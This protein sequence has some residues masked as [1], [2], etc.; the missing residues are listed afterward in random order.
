MESCTPE[1]KTQTDPS[2]DWADRLGALQ[3]NYTYSIENPYSAYFHSKLP[4]C[5]RPII[6]IITGQ[7]LLM[8][9]N[10][11]KDKTFSTLYNLNHE[12][13]KN[14]EDFL[15][16]FLNNLYEQFDN[17]SSKKTYDDDLEKDQPKYKDQAALKR[18]KKS[19]HQFA[20]EFG[21]EKKLYNLNKLARKLDGVTDKENIKNLLQQG[22]N[23]NQQYVYIPDYTE[24]IISTKEKLKRRKLK[25]IFYWISFFVSIIVGFG[26]ALVA[27]FFA[28]SSWPLLIALLVVGIPAFL[29]NYFLFRQDSYTVL[30]EIFI[31]GIYKDKDGNEISSTKKQLIRFTLFSCV[32]AAVALGFLS[33]G[34]AYA[35]IGAL[36]ACPPVA[37][38]FAAIIAIV[39]AIALATIFY[40]SM[41]GFIKNNGHSKIKEYF[42]KTYYK[43]WRHNDWSNLTKGK[44]LAHV[45]RETLRTLFNLAFLALALAPAIIVII[46]SMGLLHAQA[47]KVMTFTMH[48]SAHTSSILAYV[49][50][51]GLATLANGFFYAKGI[52]ELVEGIKKYTC[53][54]ASA[55][56]NPSTTYHNIESYFSSL[57]KNPTR[58]ID[59][60]V[61][62][63]ATVF[64]SASVVMNSEGQAMGARNS[65]TVTHYIRSVFPGTSENVAKTAAAISM[66]MGS[67]GP[68]LFACNEAIA[69][70]DVISSSDDQDQSS[71]NKGMP[72]PL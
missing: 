19:I 10:V 31:S 12:K 23:W 9:F 69:L 32:S 20:D 21:F 7:L 15:Q 44:K 71:Q 11:K 39:T 27:A 50:V 46:A 35:A 18:L 41:A 63:F 48:I 3:K 62:F 42:K 16:K 38:A 2:E 24:S 59:T 60:I 53:L 64:L 70:P 25:K 55:I 28:A 30:K 43:P 65:H 37:I 36:I 34:A 72:K 29:V 68:N 61:N 22:E 26:E 47:I 51:D 8:G 49:F 33:Y 13:E 54:F 57:R 6:E 1:N 58:L 67:G 66:G 5:K 4:F 45:A 56:A 14:S 40:S 17:I 52:I